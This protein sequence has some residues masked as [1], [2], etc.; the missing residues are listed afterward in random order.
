M[1]TAVVTVLVALAAIVCA[2]EREERILAYYSTTSITHLTTTTIT[3]LQTCL[4]VSSTSC[5]GRRKRALA[6]P[7]KQFVEELSKTE[8]EGSQSLDVE[9]EKRD[10]DKDAR[11]FTFWSTVFTTFTLTS[12]SI[13]D[14]TTVTVS[15]YCS[16]PGLTDSCF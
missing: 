7:L 9:R 1:K 8:L 10:A 16:A 11:A 2:N 12:T 5:T 6:A 13:L 4:S 14:S 3:G 15:A